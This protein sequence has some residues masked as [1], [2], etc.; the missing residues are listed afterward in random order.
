MTKISFSDT[1][2]KT[3]E[4][5]LEV[6]CRMKLGQFSTAI[7][8]AFPE[9]SLSWEELESVH[10]F[11]RGVIMPVT[12]ILSYDGHGGY[13]DQYDN[14]YGEDRELDDELDYQQK[15]FLKRANS[16]NGILGGLNSS[17][18]IGSDKIAD[19]NIAYEIRQT[20]RQYLTVKRNDGFFDYMNVGFD[21]PLNVS[22]E[23]LP[24]IEGFS[25]EKVYAVKNKNINTRLNRL[26]AAKSPNWKKM[27]ELVELN[28]D[29]PDNLES[30]RRRLNFNGETKEWE[31]ILEK[32]R[33]TKKND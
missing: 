8:E 14:Y 2:L 9:A 13:V 1:H 18:G 16:S 6:Y 24:T 25:K 17:F 31:L 5:A 10:K 21:D 11:L 3:I 29:K 19:G 28:C 7:D 27:W 15:N 20:I 23:P 12:P 33:K 32:P 26:F 4:T 22:G 30:S